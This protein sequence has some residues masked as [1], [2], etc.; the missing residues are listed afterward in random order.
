MNWPFFQNAEQEI[1]P[2]PMPCISFKEDDPLICRERYRNFLLTLPK[3]ELDRKL[4]R[5]EMKGN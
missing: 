5:H 4:A 3:A 1:N 2:G